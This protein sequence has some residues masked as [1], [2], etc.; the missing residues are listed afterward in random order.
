MPSCLPRSGMSEPG[1]REDEGYPTH[2]SL[3]QRNKS[4]SRRSDVGI[5]RRGLERIVAFIRRR[6]AQTAFFDQRLREAV[7]PSSMED[8]L[9]R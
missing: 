4:T 3:Q 8:D 2:H 9:N 5:G 6:F 7:E 1:W